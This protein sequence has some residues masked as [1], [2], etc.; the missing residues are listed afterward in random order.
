MMNIVQQTAGSIGTAVMSVIFTNHVL[1]SQAAGAYSA[2]VQGAVPADQ[3]P[4]TL[5]EQ[6]R[7]ALAE[8]FGSTYT[9]AL[10]LIAA[11]L[12]PALFLPRRKTVPT[13]GGEAGGNK[14]PSVTVMH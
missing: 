2:V 14:G 3:V 7:A 11:C 1:D 8:A 12:I 6:G 9:V 4:P 13:A 10:V 5:L